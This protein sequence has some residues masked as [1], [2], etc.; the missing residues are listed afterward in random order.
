MV[1]RLKGIETCF[2]RLG[3]ALVSVFVYGFPFE[4][5]WNPSSVTRAQTSLFSLDMPSRLKGIETRGHHRSQG[6]CRLCICLPVWRELKHCVSVILISFMWRTLYMVSRLKGIETCDSTSFIS[7]D[8]YLCI[9]FPVWRE[10]KPEHP[11]PLFSLSAFVYA[12]PFEGNWNKIHRCDRESPIQQ[13]CICFP[14][15]R[16]LKLTVANAMENADTL[17]IW[18]PVWRELKPLDMPASAACTS[19]TLCICFPV[20]RELK[21]L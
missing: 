6:W 19:F 5:N 21:H 9:W 14:V 3:S 11:S 20:W 10:L 17:W 1:S 16:E 4:G 2:H 15:W 7:R 18:F 8:H 12:F 13:L